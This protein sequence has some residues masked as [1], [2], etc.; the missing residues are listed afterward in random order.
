MTWPTHFTASTMI[1]RSCWFCTG[2]PLQRKI[3]RSGTR[4]TTSSSP[5]A[6]AC[7]AQ[8]R[9]HVDLLLWCAKTAWDLS[10]VTANTQNKVRTYVCMICV[11][12]YAIMSIVQDKFVACCMTRICQQWIWCKTGHFVCRQLSENCLDSIG[13]YTWRRALHDH[14]A[15][16]QSNHP[17]KPLQA[18]ALQH[19][20]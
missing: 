11:T 13:V 8:L 5:T 20:H 6:R 4:P 10:R 18:C 3:S 12:G 14:N 2:G 1:L 7:R 9:Q 19:A 15:S 17:Y 16:C